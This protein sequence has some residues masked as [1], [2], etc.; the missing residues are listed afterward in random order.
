[1]EQ[2][3]D[4]YGRAID[5]AGCPLA[6]LTAEQAFLGWGGALSIEGAARM[7]VDPEAIGGEIKQYAYD[8]YYEAKERF[9]PAK[10]VYTKVWNVPYFVANELEQ[11]K[12]LW[13]RLDSA[14]LALGKQAQ[15]YFTETN[16]FYGM[17]VEA[18]GMLD[19]PYTGTHQWR[20][21][22]RMTYEKHR[23]LVHEAA[24]WLLH[25]PRTEGEALETDT[26]TLQG[27][28]E[29]INLDPNT[30]EYIDPAAAAVALRG[31]CRHLLDQVCDYCGRPFGEVGLA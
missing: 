18:M 4:R 21:H 2:Q 13:G 31:K 16:L 22:K 15:Y 3:T 10:G 25:D 23:E 28:I 7:G 30:I 17:V 19:T 24:H 1:M 8:E 11:V 5:E 20:G 14:E 29:G 26:L 12:G 27:C 6:P 9:V